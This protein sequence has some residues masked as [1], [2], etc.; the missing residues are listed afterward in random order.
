MKSFLTILGVAALAAAP[1][2]AQEAPLADNAQAAVQLL[3]LAQDRA[4]AGDVEMARVLTEQA[5]KLLEPSPTQEVTLFEPFALDR[6]GPLVL[7]FPPLL[8]L[9]PA[10][11]YPVGRDLQLWIEDSASDETQEPQAAEAQVL[12]C[13][14]AIRAEL[15]AI[16]AELAEL[17]A[18]MAATRG[19][20]SA[21][22]PFRIWTTPEA[23]F[24][25]VPPALPAAP[26]P[27]AGVMV[28]PTILR[29]EAA[30]GG[31]WRPEV[32]RAPQPYGEISGG[33]WLRLG[34][35]EGGG[36]TAP[37]AVVHPGEGAAGQQAE[38]ERLRADLAAALGEIQRLQ[39][40]LGENATAVPRGQGSR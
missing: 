33:E 3:A 5:M 35:A 15:Q 24:W 23:G 20:A 27:P 32:V 7:D 28:V 2:T 25:A 9:Y 36:A 21:P 34:Y 13:L 38:I 16:R 19:M 18:E 40:M 39:Q 8:Q 37:S 6:A 10:L 26:A 1:L 17:R 31:I 22:L 30:A 4:Q 14:H 12:E 29:Y 11:S